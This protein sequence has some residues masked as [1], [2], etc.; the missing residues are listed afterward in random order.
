LETQ[1]E[2]LFICLANIFCSKT[3]I[4]GSQ[5]RIHRLQLELRHG[6]LFT[7]RLALLH[8][9]VQAQLLALAGQADKIVCQ[10]RR[11]VLTR[12]GCAKELLHRTLVHADSRAVQGAGDS[13][14]SLRGDNFIPPHLVASDGIARSVKHPRLQPRA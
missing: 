1:I 2:L 11:F 9:P 6:L 14:V 3:A 13:D 4:I 7:T 10:E 8:Q 12:A 5:T